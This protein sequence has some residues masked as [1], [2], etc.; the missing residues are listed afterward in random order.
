[1]NLIELVRSQ[2]TD[3]VVGNLASVVSETRSN[4]QQTLLGGTLP[5]TLAGLF[6]TFAGESG[7]ARLLSLIA[8]GQYDGNLLSNL[9]GALSGGAQTDALLNIG[10][11][12]LGTLFGGRTDAVTD[13][14]ANISGIRRSSAA[15]LLALSAPLVL[16]V[17]GQHIKNTGLSAPALAG[18]LGSQR[19][20][21]AAAA[22]AGLASA[23]GVANFLTPPANEMTVR[24][25][26]IWPWIIVP[27]ATLLLF[28]GLR[29]C[30]TEPAAEPIIAP[31]TR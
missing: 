28:F 15:S 16:N 7:A 10:K 31:A 23:M 1:M 3:E 19:E 14:V 2:L 6:N 12:L 11:G 9:S 22:P 4:T 25:A 27:I 26:A 21:V 13:S 17:L 8:S 30:S 24:K 5:A 18:L 20:W 29:Q